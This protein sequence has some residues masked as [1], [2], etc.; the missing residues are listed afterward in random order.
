M[1]KCTALL[2]SALIVLPLTLLSGTAHADHGRGIEVS[3]DF[4]VASSNFTSCP[5]PAAEVT[6]L[7][8]GVRVTLLKSEV[9]DVEHRDV[10][11]DVNVF[12]V[13]LHPDGSFEIGDLLNSGSGTGR[14]K[15][16]GVR[17]AT[18]MGAVSMGDGSTA[19]VQFSLG[20]TGLSSPYSGTA[21]VDEPACPSGTAD[22]A[23]RGRSREA[24]ASG[25]LTI[26]GI[27]Q[28][29]TVAAGPASLLSEHDEGACTPM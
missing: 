18:V 15:F 19:M 8:T 4:S 12:A 6:C 2:S 10:S 25:Q 14:A 9:G 21:S 28:V 26:G 29:P 27:V 1:K 7:G 23:F 13:H 5:T 17:S 11:I 22:I 16:N 3:Y 24:L 20:G